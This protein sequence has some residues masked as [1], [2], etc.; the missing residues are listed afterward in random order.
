M[1]LEQDNIR[2]Q[3]HENEL[4]LSPPLTSPSL[5]HTSSSSETTIQTSST[6]SQVSTLA[7]KSDQSTGFSTVIEGHVAMKRHSKEPVGLEEKLHLPYVPRANIAVST[8]MPDGTPGWREKHSH[9]SV[10]EQHCLFWDRDGDGVIWMT[11]TFR[12]FRQLGYNLIMSFLGMMIINPGF[13]FFSGNSIFPDPFC[14]I[15]LAN[16]HRAKH[17]SDSG[18]F[19]TEGRFVPNKFEAIF[20]KYDDE[21]KGG[22]TF[23]QGLRMLYR[24]RCIA[25]GAGIVAASFEWI[26]TYVLFWPDDGVITKE[27]M[28]TVYDGSVFFEIARERQRLGLP[29]AATDLL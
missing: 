24:N 8:E 16:I 5:S 19:D 13:S 6:S 2:K 29:N 18:A 7:Q 26:I 22:I 23:W 4:P 14:R 28:R 1:D 25:D 9:Q 11:D 15:T 20:T 17:G 27:Q 10:M 3:N 21:G 12:G